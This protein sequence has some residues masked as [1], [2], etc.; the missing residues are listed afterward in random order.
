[1]QGWDLRPDRSKL[2]G[3]RERAP[4]EREPERQRRAEAREE[5]GLALGDRDALGRLATTGGGARAADT[6]FATTSFPTRE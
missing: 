1:M 5:P 4:K 2:G 6:A 3:E